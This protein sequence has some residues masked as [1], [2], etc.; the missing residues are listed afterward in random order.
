MTIVGLKEEKALEVWGTPG[1]GW[2]LMRTYEVLAASGGAGPKLREGDLQ[3]PEGVY[4]LVGFN[5][6]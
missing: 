4:R 5:P 3:V 1:S 6:R 2:T